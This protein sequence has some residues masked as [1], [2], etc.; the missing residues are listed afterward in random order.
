MKGW[1]II[2]G[3]LGGIGPSIDPQVI[4]TLAILNQDR[5]S[6]GCG[7]FNAKASHVKSVDNAK[8]FLQDPYLSRWII[9]S[10]RKTWAVCGHTRGGT[11]GGKST[12]NA[13]PFRYGKIIGSHN[14]I[15]DCPAKYSVDSEYAMDLLSQNKPG[16]Y[17]EA[18]GDVQ[19]WYVLTWYDS[20][21]KSLYL[22]NWKGDLSIAKYGDNCYYSSSAN[23]LKTALGIG[24]KAITP[25][26]HTKVIRFSLQSKK[27]GVVGDQLADFTGKD[28]VY[29]SGSSVNY[30]RG[31]HNATQD[32]D[33]IPYSRSRTMHDRKME[34]NWMEPT[35]FVTK[36]PDGL[37]CCELMN[38]SFR[39]LKGP[40]QQVLDQEYLGDVA[41]TSRWRTPIEIKP[42]QEL[43]TA[44]TPLRPLPD[45]FVHPSGFVKKISQDLKKIEHEVKTI[46]PVAQT[47][48]QIKAEFASREIFP[49]GGDAEDR[50]DL[51]K[52]QEMMDKEAA[53]TQQLEFHRKERL[54]FL[55]RAAK[56]TPG[57]ARSVMVDEG[58]FEE[59]N[60]CFED[61]IC[62]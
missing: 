30:A 60:E 26:A 51:A 38:K 17:Q 56:L 19:G 13:H 61:L 52:A 40:Y 41:G 43:V 54:E 36:F 12:K 7:F 53:A 3:L 49:E 4:R 6:D 8:E 25:I 34:A 47:P 22:L 5:G 35:G 59:G 32:F 16:A 58:Y 29:Q 9:D 37:W 18:L 62:S 27:G 11:R 15:L 20:R 23:H 33:R 57:E 1:C 14:G 48:S 50:A 21:D 28:R 10:A 44:A 45:G 55:T 42:N 31:H 39:Q 24:D 2:C 46:G